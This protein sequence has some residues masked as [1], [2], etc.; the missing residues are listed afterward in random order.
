MKKLKIALIGM[1]ISLVF[2][3]LTGCTSESAKKQDAAASEAKSLTP[4]KLVEAWYAKGE[5]GGY[6]AALQQDYYKETGIDM[7][8]QPGGPQVSALQMVA[9]GK[10]DFG[11]SYGDEI[12]KAREQ[13]IPVVALLSAFQYSPQV[14]MYHVGEQIES[15]E[16]LNGRAVY[17]TPG[18]LY[19]E[20]IKKKYKLDQAQEFAYSGQLVNFINDAKSL[21]QGYIT[22]EPYA[23]QQQNVDISYLKVKDSGYANYADILFTT[24]DYIAKH[25]DIVEAMVKASQKGWNYYL[26]NYKTV[27]PFIQTYNKDM[28]VDAMDYEAEHQKEFI[29]TDE[30]KERGIGYMTEERWA[31]IQEQM[32]GIHV[33]TKQQ[34][35]SKAFTTQFLD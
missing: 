9:S 25:T 32:L 21:N 3:I 29:L 19:W 31:T 12:L 10:A 14:F 22:N 30:T 26:D 24:E 33:L 23:L 17:V 15:F 5:D 11:I 18:A 1:V 27:N 4:I 7:T 8:I 16:D 34:D 35:V 28:P 13:G 20:Y 2:V 6:F